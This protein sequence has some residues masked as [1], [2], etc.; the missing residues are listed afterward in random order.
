MRDAMKSATRL[1]R[2]GVVLLAAL[3][4]SAVWPPAHAA[5]ST[6]VDDTASCIALMQ[7]QADDLARRIKA[8]DKT[9]EP[10]LQAE[11]RRAGALIGR[12]YL[13]GLHDHNEAKARL[14]A[15]RDRQAAWDDDR[16]KNVHRACLT[17]ADAELAAA[18]GPQRFIVERFARARFKHMLEPQ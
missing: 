9:Q 7:T 14:K 15:A 13:D 4:W 10:V 2:A 6:A 5:G 16:K 1:P 8:G 3:S 12:T 11:L 17:R 18:S